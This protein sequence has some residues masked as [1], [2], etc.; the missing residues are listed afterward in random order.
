MMMTTVDRQTQNTDRQSS[1]MSVAVLVD[2]RYDAQRRWKS[3][4]R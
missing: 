4:A 1:Y 3:V 2:V